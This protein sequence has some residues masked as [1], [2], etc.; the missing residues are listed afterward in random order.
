M[1]WEKTTNLEVIGEH[2]DDEEW[3]GKVTGGGWVDAFRK[4]GKINGQHTRIYENVW[5]EV[6]T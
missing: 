5:K 4:D 1:E 6:R 2:K 3:N